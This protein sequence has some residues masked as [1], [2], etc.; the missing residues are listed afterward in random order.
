[1]WVRSIVKGSIPRT[2]DDIRLSGRALDRDRR[3]ALKRLPEQ[4]L[5]YPARDFPDLRLEPN[6][7]L[8]AIPAVRYAA[9]YC[10]SSPGQAPSGLTG[11]FIF[12]EI[13]TGRCPPP[14]ARIEPV[15][16]FP[17][18]RGST[19]YEKLGFRL[20]PVPGWLFVRRG[21]PDPA[22]PVPGARPDRGSPGDVPTVGDL[23]T[24]GRSDRAGQ[25][26]SARTSL[27]KANFHRY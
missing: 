2:G 10:R 20:P 9:S 14:M 13:E 19:G 15:T 5:Q 21:P 17:T 23:N 26:T 6:V 22:H 24:C 3:V 11:R 18:R 4:A 12:R 27:H 8:E 16:A 25:K 7:R 1:M